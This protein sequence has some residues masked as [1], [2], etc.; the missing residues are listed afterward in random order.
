MVEVPEVMRC[1]LLCILEAVEDGLRLVEVLEVLEVMR[2]VL[3][4]PHVR[5]CGGFEISIAGGS[6][7]VAVPQNE[8]AVTTT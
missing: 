3:G 2:C 8:L 4:T 1:V 7:L 6:F 5:S